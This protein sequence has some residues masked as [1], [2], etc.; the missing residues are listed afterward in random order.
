MTKRKPTPLD[1]DEYG[2]YTTNK[3]K[4]LGILAMPDNL[5][6]D[7]EIPDAAM[8]LTAVMVRANDPKDGQ[9]FINDTIEWFKQHVKDDDHGEPVSEASD[10]EH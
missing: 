3:G 7:D 4:G 6:D 9:A 2:L 1:P 8:F 10:T 5:K